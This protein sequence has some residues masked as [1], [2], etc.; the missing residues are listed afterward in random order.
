MQNKQREKCN[1]FVIGWIMVGVMG[2]LLAGCKSENPQTQTADSRVYKVAFASFGPDAA[3]DNAITGYLDALNDEGFKEGQN[4]QVLRKHGFGEIGQLPQIMQS[5][6]AQN[7]DLIVPMSTPGLAAAFGTIKK[8]PMVFVY[9]Y[10]PIGAGAGKDFNDHLPLVTGVESFPPIEET[11]NVIRELVPN[12][13]IIGTLYNASEAN[14]VKAVQIAR[15]VLAPM[16]ISL[17]AVSIASTADVLLGTQAL[18][19]RNPDAVWVT[20]DNTVLQALEGVIRPTLDAKLPLIL[21]DP[22]FIDRGALAAVGISWH[23][24]GYAAGKIAA[25]VLRGENPAHIPIISLAERRIVLNRKI[26]QKLNLIIPPSLEQ[27]AEQ[28]GD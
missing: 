6:E 5:L 9:T 21:N 12:V 15:G 2:L 7:L 18:I 13:K 8:T 3:A 1:R 24:S 17:E 16:G 11:M 10:D 23:T 20:G 26:A 22:E 28:E 19:T 14:S 4:L 25:R 27:K